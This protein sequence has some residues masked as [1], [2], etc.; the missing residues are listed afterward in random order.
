MLL[1][2]L[3]STPIV[4]ACCSKTGV[5]RSTYYRW[6]NEDDD[7]RKKVEECIEKGRSAVSDLSESRLIQKIDAGDMRAITFWLNNNEPRYKKTERKV[8]TN[9]ATTWIDIVRLASR[10]TDMDSDNS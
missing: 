5:P 1:E 10:G 3:F 9:E 7:F 6:L 8:A 4:L 2:E